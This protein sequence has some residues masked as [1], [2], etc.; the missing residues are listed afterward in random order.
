MAIVNFATVLCICGIACQ[1]SLKFAHSPSPPRGVGGSSI[2][3]YLRL[4]SPRLPG[5]KSAEC[6][7]RTKSKNQADPE[8]QH[9][10]PATVPEVLNP[11]ECHPI[12]HIRFATGRI[13]K[14]CPRPLVI[15]N[16]VSKSDFTFIEGI[17]SFPLLQGL[18]FVEFL[19]VQRL[20]SLPFCSPE[21]PP[22][23]T[24]PPRGLEK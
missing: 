15:S 5:H 4:H 7:K 16:L 9:L 24:R 20:N 1:G 17:F 3:L 8:T 6:P 22:P 18:C 13:K 11:C 23:L 2:I 12:S 10:F 21:C 14:T 19:L